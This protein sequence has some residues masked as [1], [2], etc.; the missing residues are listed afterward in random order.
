M[1]ASLASNVGPAWADTPPPA[2]TLM[3]RVSGLKQPVDF[4]FV[5]G[6]PDLTLVCEKE[7][8]LRWVDV[9][10]KETGVVARF[11]VATENELGLLGLAF[12][13]D[14]SR[15]G[16]FFVHHTA[17]DRYS[18]VEEWRVSPGAD[19]RATAPQL[20]HV[21][22][23]QRQPYANHNAGQLLFGPDGML[24]VP[25][26]DGGLAADPDRNGQD[27]SSWLG[28]IL[29]IDVNGDEPYS[30]PD[31]NPFVAVDGV[32]PETWAWGVRN[33][34]R[35]TFDRRGRLV[36]ADVG[37]EAWEE[38]SFAAAGDNL[39]WSRV[40]GLECFPPRATCSQQGLRKPFWVYGREQG[41]SITGGRV[42]AGSV[43]GL[44]GMY[45]LADWASGRFWALPLPDSLDGRVDAGDVLE[46]G[47]WDLR[48]ISF[49][50]APDGELWVADFTGGRLLE[51][52]SD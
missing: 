45:V 24:Y 23:R 38:L 11:A 48:P 19:L 7:G 22:L 16:R 34:W 52:G 4:A 44:A 33:P 1:L 6:Q 42:Y 51:I 14:F 17:E 5:P 47:R 30:V 43:S 9:S 8:V 2:I 29:R 27:R 26:G 32:R 12:H 49:A 39:G 40:E 41:Q 31:D 37:Q 10:T 20:H 3:E 50:E 35:V 15:N 13:P 25:F 21:V 28:S 46:I 18:T 36:V